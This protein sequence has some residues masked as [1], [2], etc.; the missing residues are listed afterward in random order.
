M[1]GDG[2]NVHILG[3]GLAGLAAAIKLVNNGFEV[4]VHDR[5]ASI[6]SKFGYHVNAIREQVVSGALEELKRLGLEYRPCAYIKKAIRIAPA[7]SSETYGTSY[8]LFERGRGEDSLENQMYDLCAELGVEFCFQ[9]KLSS[10][11]KVI[12]IVAT[13]APKDLRNILGVGYAYSMDKINLAMDELYLV[14][15]NGIAPQGYVCLM[16]GPR[17]AMLLS[18]SFTEQNRVRLKKMLDAGLESGVLD[19]ALS[20]ALAEK[21]IFGYGYV[22]EDPILN[23]QKNG[24]LYV[25][26]S[27]G[28]QDA[29]RGFGVDYALS[30]GLIAAQSIISGV[31]YRELLSCK[32]GNEFKDLWA[33]REKLNHLTNNDYS[34]MISSSGPKANINE[35]AKQK[36][37]I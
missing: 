25:G 23:A 27:C 10:N 24:R 30:T 34:L 3:A 12:D 11:A 8:V 35:Y 1:S 2:R 36:K 17:D 37:R 22:Q 32:Y 7:A 29:R 5:K 28:F 13:G 18:V 31:P 26:E 15:D 33:A 6:G 9:S 16:P 19:S 21:N 14:Y 4:S 20:G